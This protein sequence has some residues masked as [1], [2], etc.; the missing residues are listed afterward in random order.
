MTSVFQVHSHIL[1]FLIITTWGK[2]CF[3]HSGITKTGV[4]PSI[5]PLHPS[6]LPHALCR[7]RGLLD[8]LTWRTTQEPLPHSD[9][10]QTATL[11]GLTGL[12]GLPPAQGHIPLVVAETSFE[13]PSETV[14][15]CQKNAYFVLA[16]TWPLILSYLKKKKKLTI[17]NLPSTPFRCICMCL[18]Q[19]KTVFLKD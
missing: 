18:L 16:S 5:L 13:S 19:P 14:Q 6:V 2:R 1:S 15:G 11:R 4:A 3:S 8:T 12:A 17:I 9:P 10:L 7:G